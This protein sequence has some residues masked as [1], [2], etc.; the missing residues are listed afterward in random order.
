M[1]C[2]KGDIGPALFEGLDDPPRRF[3]KAS[4]SVEIF[5]NYGD[6]FHGQIL[7]QRF[8]G[9]GVRPSDRIFL[10]RIYRV[11]NGSYSGGTFLGGILPVF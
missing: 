6:C 9:L 4:M 11:G 2:Q 8:S 5:F 7:P 10:G 1:G 3:F